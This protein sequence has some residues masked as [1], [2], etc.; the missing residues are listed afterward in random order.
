M[1]STIRVPFENKNGSV[2]HAKSHYAAYEKLRADQGAPVQFYT[3][4]GVPEGFHHECRT[5]TNGMG[6]PL[7][8]THKQLAGSIR[9]TAPKHVF[10]PSAVIPTTPALFH[11]NPKPVDHRALPV[12]KPS[13]A[14]SGYSGASDYGYTYT[15]R[16]ASFTYGASVPMPR[17][18]GVP[19]ALPPQK[20]FAASRTRPVQ[21]LAAAGKQTG[22][23][24]RNMRGA[25]MHN[26]TYPQQEDFR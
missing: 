7:A 4:R 26:T 8:I 21:E 20:H 14:K 1:S 19:V 6:L 2:S 24:N 15:G 22:V 25:T 18:P 17:E 12:F 13:A 16:G 23:F 11:H 10:D 9:D 3:R 5:A